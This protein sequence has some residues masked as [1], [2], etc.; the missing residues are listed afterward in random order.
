MLNMLTGALNNAPSPAAPFHTFWMPQQASSFATQ[1]DWIFYFIF[2]I[3]L[4]FF[5]LIVALAFYMVLRFRR[6]PGVK[7]QDSPNHNTALEITWSVIP[8]IIV[9]L[10]FLAGFRGFVDMSFVP[11]GAYQI[12]VEAQK[13]NWN[14]SYPNGFVDTELHV[15]V[16]QPV[17]LTMKS[18]DV[19]HS[20]FVP[21]FRIK[22][23]VVPGR[24]NKTW[25]EATKTG[26]YD[27]F[28]AEYCGTG[29]SDMHTIV[30]VE[31][32]G[33]FQEYLNKASKYLDTLPPEQ[34]GEQLYKK[35]G[36]SQC[37][38]IDG[39]PGTG[40]SLLGIWG[41][42]QL[43]TGGGK[44]V[45]DENYVRESILAPSSKI[46]AGFDNVMPTFQGRL[47]EKEIDYLIAFIKS[48]EK[49]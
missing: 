47:K 14:F 27:L 44:A 23:D 46:V 21:Q 43:L 18:L 7:P 22:R 13:W 24:Y 33:A 38:S 31:E 6:R 42:E 39:K 25:F 30:V 17:T 5:L 15:P 40:P 48:L 2:Y 19:V 8:I 16:N 34:A 45:V 36:C 32:P 37:H 29:H 9:I 41:H 4:F 11:S 3:A 1:V 28:C 49:K 10:I 20:F 12:G 35:R 26:T